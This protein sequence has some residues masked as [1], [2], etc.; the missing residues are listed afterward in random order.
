MKIWILAVAAP[1][2]LAAAPPAPAPDV[3]RKP[4]ENTVFSFVTNGG[5]TV[6]LCKGPKSAYLVYR[7]GTATKTELQYPAVLDASSWRKFTYWEYHRGGGAHNAGRDTHQLSFSIGK[8][9]Y[10]IVDE[11]VDIYTKDQEEVERRKVGV[12]VRGGSRDVFIAGKETSADWYLQ[13][14]DAQRKKVVL[15]GLPDK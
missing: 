3:L 5:R 14:D 9:V 1:C 11:T 12:W 10:E 8:T 15:F 4:G 13:L 6:S 7:F 2:W